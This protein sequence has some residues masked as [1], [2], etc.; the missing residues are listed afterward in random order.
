MSF[1]S[2]NES[3]FSSSSDNDDEDVTY[4]N[5]VTEKVINPKIKYSLTN[6]QSLAIIK[7][8]TK[9]SNKKQV[10]QW[11]NAN[12]YKNYNILE[13]LDGKELLELSLQK[14][15]IFI[16]NK[17]IAIKLYK[18]LH[19][20]DHNVFQTPLHNVTNKKMNKIELLRSKQKKQKKIK[21]K[22]LSKSY[23]PS[24]KDNKNELIEKYMVYV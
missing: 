14:L 20:Y 16:K 2:S 8:I 9:L 7:R 10:K 3:L 13:T 22:M 4:N 21:K 23:K 6:D 15:H 18:L 19:P 11:L 12:G 1:L 17:S 5:N 24:N